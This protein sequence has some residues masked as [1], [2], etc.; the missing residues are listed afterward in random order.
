MPEAAEYNAEFNRRKT[1]VQAFLTSLM[2]SAK[3]SILYKP[4]HVMSLQIADR[5]LGMLQKTL[6]GEQ[7]L[8][9]EVKAKTVVIEEIALPETPEVAAFASSLHTLGVGG[10]LFTNR[11]TQESMCDFFRALMVK[12]D[13]K[14]T[15]SDL[16]KALQNTRI[17]GMTLS[18]ILSFVSTGET[19][20]KE[21]KPGDLSEDQI[22]AFLKAPTLA[23]FLTFLLHQNEDL[24]GK[25]AE[26]VTGHIDRLLY[27]EL[28]VQRFEEAMPWAL[29][30]PRIRQRWDWF[31]RTAAWK[32][33]T[34]GRRAEKASAAAWSRPILAS[35]AAAV[36]DAE[37]ER[38][39][40]HRVHEHRESMVWALEETHRILDRPVGP[41]QPKF[42]L[43]AYLRL[44]REFAR[45][46]RVDILLAEFDRWTA[47]EKAPAF[48]KLY[49]GFRQGVRDKVVTPVF[50]EL[51]VQHLGSVPMASAEVLRKVADFCLFLGE[52]LVP[53]LLEELRRLSD[54]DLRQR[55]CV[56]LAAVG[57]GPGFD[58]ILKALSD[59]DWFLV[60]NVIGIV[61]EIGR[62]EAVKH[63]APVLMHPHAKAREAAMKFITKFGGADAA[64][65]LAHFI[66]ASPH[67]E[68]TPKAVIAL[69]LL[70]AAGID[71]RLLEAYPKVPD[72]A[73]KVSLIT[74]L[75]RF[76]GPEAIRFLK[77]TARRTWYEVFTGL[78]KELRQAAKGA[79][80]QMRQE[81]RG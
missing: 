62:P 58:H 42:A 71:K 8:T 79:L 73:T 14:H 40:D 44:L 81:G 59:D 78:N 61:T 34:R 20:A 54:K 38:I 51:F 17:E 32:P 80:E 67:R 76:P 49:A 57:R 46:G 19:E 68:E 33:K 37:L 10:V 39:S 28:S 29:Y 6:G 75:G 22:A 43:A 52:D 15:L 12:V 31:R 35:W 41:S 53:M 69:S 70:R 72:Y 16:Q 4:G 50:A 11:M 18:F 64:D 55:F 9:L 74:A 47:M 23:D 65:G 21:Q 24:R 77:E 5:M 56:L 7:T 45:D 63:V 1:A 60:V 25:E 48:A 3:T 66:A 27:K 36:D 13:E 26:A 2:A 30:D